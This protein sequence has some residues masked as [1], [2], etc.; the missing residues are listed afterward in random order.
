MS[1]AGMRA[2]VFANGDLNDG[3][4]VQAALR[5]APESLI[6]VADG[7]ARLAL[8]CGLV[9]QV[10]VGDLDSLTPGEVDDLRAQGAEIVRYPAEKD[11][12]D[13]ELALMIAVRRGTTWIRVIG[14]IGGRIDQMLANV[15]LLTRPDLAGRDTRLVAGPQTLWLIGP[16]EHP[17]DG[18]PGDT[19]SLL[20]LAGDAHD[21]RTD[22]LEYPLRGEILRF[23]PARGVS[24]VMLGVSAR[25]ALSAGLLVVVHTPGKA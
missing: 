21:V 18:A 19:I 15:S 8:A 3:P 22:G 17:L 25:V 1:A 6:V 11:E 13:L 16:G 2:L 24:N 4:A 9:P 20:P 5:F 10:V 14:A 7:G 12:T 23:G